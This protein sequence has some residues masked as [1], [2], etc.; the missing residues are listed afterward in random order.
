MFVAYEVGLELIRQLRPLMPAFKLEDRDYEDN[1][2][3]AANSIVNNIGEGSRRGGR[4]QKRFYEFAAGSASEIKGALDA[5][6]AWGYP[7]DLGP[8]RATVDR[9]MGLLWGLT[10]RKAAV[11]ADDAQCVKRQSIA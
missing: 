8:V 5:A 10:H 4:E 1:L 3:R 2:R 7:I 9:L 11:A 6:D